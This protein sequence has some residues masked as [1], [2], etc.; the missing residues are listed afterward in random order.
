LQRFIVLLRQTIGHTGQEIYRCENHK[1]TQTNIDTNPCPA[2]NSNPPS[3][4][5]SVAQDYGSQ[6][7]TRKG[8]ECFTSVSVITQVLG[9]TLDGF[10]PFLPT[11]A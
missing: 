10:P 1:S 2:T 4:S 3:G 7:A 5:V 8:E 6:T 9:H 11:T